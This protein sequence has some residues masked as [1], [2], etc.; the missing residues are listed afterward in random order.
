MYN[1]IGYNTTVAGKPVL[2][3]SLWQDDA[4]L[5]GF[6]F[7]WNGTGTWTNNTW[8]GLSGK[9]SWANATKTLSST[10]GASVGFKWYCND[11]DSY[12][13]STPTQWLTTTSPIQPVI[14]GKTTIGASTDTVP[15]GYVW[16]VRFQAPGD[17]RATRISAYIHGKY[18][19]GLVK[20]MIYS[21][22][23]GEIGSLLAESNEITLS[24]TWMWHNF[25]VNYNI[26]A[27][28]YYWFAVYA[29][30]EAQY[31]YDTGLTN[32]EAYAWGWTYPTVPVNFDG[33]Y[34]PGYMNK[35]PSVF[36][37]YTPNQ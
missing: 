22:A 1:N 31:R 15:V 34:G 5:S 10:V 23:N 18:Q 28:K 21:D 2:F 4:G 8:T 36:V 9:S 27:G 20:A 6:I 26:Q 12:Y 24:T 32:Q 3:S 7:S 11:T 25:T 14:F 35:E 33:V 13:T 16:A 30:V 17:G 37:T 29:S 19:S